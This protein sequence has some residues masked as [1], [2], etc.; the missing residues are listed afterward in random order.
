MPENIGANLFFPVAGCAFDNLFDSV[1]GLKVHFDLGPGVGIP[2]RD[3]QWD[4]SLYG[5]FWLM[6]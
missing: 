6:Q 4:S 3:T 1:V 2:D 5:A